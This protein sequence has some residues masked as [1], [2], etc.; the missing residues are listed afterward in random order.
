MRSWFSRRRIL[1]ARPRIMLETL[2]ERIVFDAAVDSGADHQDDGTSGASQDQ[3]PADAQSASEP[4]GSPPDAAAGAAPDPITTI[5]D[6]DLKVILISNALDQID[7]LSAAAREGA[8]V[9]VY[10]AGE[11]SLDSV[12]DQLRDQ[13]TA[14]GQQI[15]QLAWLTHGD[16]GVLKVGDFLVFSAQTVAENPEPWQAL[17]SLMADGARIDLYGCD[18]ALG[19]EG[20]NLVSTL[21]GTT[22]VVVWAS[23]DTTGSGST[24]DWDLEVHTGESSLPSLIDTSIIEDYAIVLDN[25]SMTNAGF[26]T[27]DITGWTNTNIYAVVSASTGGNYGG[28]DAGASPYASTSTYMLRLDS[29][30]GTGDLAQPSRIQ[31]SFTCNSYDDLV[32]AY[33][34]VTSDGDP[35]SN[36]DEFGYR[37]TVNGEQ[38]VSYLIHSGD[39]PPDE[40]QLLRATGWQEVTIDLSAYASVGDSIVFEIWAG[41]TIDN[42]YDAWAFVDLPTPFYHVPTA[43]AA[44]LTVQMNESIT[45]QV[46][47]YDP[48]LHGASQVS[49]DV[50]MGYEPT[51]GALAAVDELGAATSPQYDAVNGYY[52]QI[53]TYTPDSDYWGPDSFL[54]TFST[55]SGSWKGFVTGAG[56]SIGAA[57]ESY[58]TYDLAL[59]DLNRDGNMDLVTSNANLSG[60]SNQQNMYYMSDLSGFFQNGVS[61]DQS[62][63]ADSISIAVGDLNG[64]GY[65]D[66]VVRNANSVGSVYIWDNAAGSFQPASQL[67]GSSAGSGGSIDL[68]DLDGD[69]DLDAVI[70][71]S[72]G[73][74]RI[75]WNNGDGTFG[76]SYT[77]L[78]AT[79]GTTSV[80]K[81]GDFNGDG[82]IDIL[83][84]KSNNN[85]APIHYNDG[86]GV[87]TTAN[88][89]YIGVMRVSC[90][91]V[92]DV[93]GD[94]DLD[95]VLGRSGTRTN[96]FV[97]NGGND[98]SGYTTWTSATITGDN[99][100]TRGIALTDVDRDGD[101]DVLVADN[102]DP[103]RLYLFNSGSGTFSAGT[104]ISSTDLDALS[105]SVGDVDGDGD[106]DL[107][108]GIDNGNNLYFENNGF[109]VGSTTMTHG[110]PAEVTIHVEAI[111]NWS[112]EKA[113]DHYDGWTM[114]ETYTTDPAP[115]AYIL[116]EY[117]TF[118]I[119]ANQ[120]G[121]TTIDW[122]EAL[123]DYYDG[124][125]QM[126]FSFHTL[127]WVPG[128]PG[129]TIDGSQTAHTAAILSG[130]LRDASLFQ[131]VEI[132]QEIYLDGL[133]FRWDISY[134]NTNPTQPDGSEFDAEQFVAVY[135]YDVSSGT[136]EQVWVT[137]NG[138][139]AAVVGTM[140]HYQVEL[141]ADSDLVQSIKSGDVQLMIEV[142]VCGLDWYLDVAIDDF[143]L[144]P[145]RH[146]PAFQINPLA[147]ST[148]PVTS[149]DSITG[150]VTT[151]SKYSFAEYLLEPVTPLVTFD[152]SEWVATGDGTDIWNSSG[153]GALFSSVGSGNMGRLWESSGLIPEELRPSEL[154]AGIG[155]Q[156][157]SANGGSLEAGVQ[158]PSDDGTAF[159]EM[160]S[161]GNDGATEDTP[162]V[163]ELTGGDTGDRA[164]ASQ[165]IELPGGQ[166]S[167]YDTAIDSEAGSEVSDSSL[168]LD[169]VKGIV[170]NMEDID[171]WQ[172]I[173]ASPSAWA[174]ALPSTDRTP[175][176]MKPLPGGSFVVS[177]D[178]LDVHDLLA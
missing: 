153:V 34:F 68:A 11:D 35:Y 76:A 136:P 163:S 77:S 166:I 2:E 26:E 6:Q 115:P 48:D 156:R 103:A 31:Q 70:G 32:F 114:T 154:F 66:A 101:L 24:A 73:Q 28:I 3:Q 33:N 10:D 117:G 172:V 171:A 170:F 134:W 50:V 131:V 12:I 98:G 161:Q 119:I 148:V 105:L 37:V 88:T 57:G 138:Q 74:D 4:A 27:G 75:Y 71:S 125:D 140:A 135:L 102:D 16:P 124:N 100:D 29:S 72:S 150:T 160:G 121:G 168:S 30:Q 49:F 60:S 155:P 14:T 89:R 44:S 41:N 144:V 64:D 23:D 94:G 56:Q 141:A 152:N 108:V 91:D 145:S 54:F 55:P 122:G 167:A 165:D 43:D 79:S 9:I 1:A 45:F 61:M 5:F 129:I 175:L 42:Q 7:Q 84:G 127:S 25:A 39:V 132:P 146:Y 86:Y 109:L 36:Y 63:T 18:I 157:S 65:Q 99:R 118:A 177:I 143:T 97:T 17:G 82:Y 178:L 58:D 90:A 15:G 46:I 47:G 20:L 110:N 164:Q 95:I 51:H 173:N 116:P 62:T 142:R 13:V 130:G 83:V 128:M 85:N 87:F 151:V 93:D 59:V 53:Y 176:A 174:V 162:V 158:A 67:Q 149:A 159:A 40:W 133:E 107:V 38:A 80:V 111:Y 113:G 21:A 123:Y 69:G 120:P 112:F 22:D 104:N 96:Y 137:T 78:P 147:S 19:S 139:D 52:Y 106:I 81:T 169:P 8:Q 92:G 126:Q